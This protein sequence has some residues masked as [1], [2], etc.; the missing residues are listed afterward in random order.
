MS[1]STP[2]S[3]PSSGGGNPIC[4]DCNKGPYVPDEEDE[5]EV[6][7]YELRIER[8]GCAKE[9]YALQDCYHD[10]DRRWAKCKDEM[11]EFR[12]CMAAQAAKR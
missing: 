3:K 2:D 5:D 12:K 1:N 10:N 9:H 8:S 4:E 11:N 7:E 6:D